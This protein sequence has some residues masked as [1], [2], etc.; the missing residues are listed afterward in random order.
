MYV[1]VEPCAMCAGALV[2]AR[3]KRLCFGAP[4]PKAGACG[5]VRNIIEDPQF[6]HKVDVVKG[7]CAERCSEMMSDF[8]Q[9][10]RAVG[11]K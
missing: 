10:K 11:K 9:G 7:I 6:N 3:L 5:S 8:F 1:T 4:D 2:L